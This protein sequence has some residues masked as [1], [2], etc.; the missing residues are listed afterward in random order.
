M[1]VGEEELLSEMK[2]K[3]RYNIN[4]AKKKE[5]KIFSVN[6]NCH[7]EFISRSNDEMPKQVRHDINY[8]ITR[9][10]TKSD[11]ILE[12]MIIDKPLPA[13]T[14]AGTILKEL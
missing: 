10:L 7:P 9:R 2:Q 12:T 11:E 6:K 5:I 13:G 4:L 1:G 8:Y 14:Y 3:T